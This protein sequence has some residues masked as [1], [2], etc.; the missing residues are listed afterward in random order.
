MEPTVEIDREE[1]ASSEVASG[2]GL[3]KYR[4]WPFPLNR[5][6]A[7]ILGGVGLVGG[8]AL[9]ARRLGSRHWSRRKD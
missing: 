5:P 1:S 7:L 6:M 4:D 8:V 2:S 9:A 3:R